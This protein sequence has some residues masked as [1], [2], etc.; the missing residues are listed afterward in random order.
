MAGQQVGDRS[1]VTA[2]QAGL[3]NAV[4]QFLIAVLQF[5]QMHRIAG[6]DHFA[7][8]LIDPRQQFRQ[9]APARGGQ[10]GGQGLVGIAQGRARRGR[11]PGQAG[12][13]L[14]QVL[15]VL[16]Q[17]VLQGRDGPRQITRIRMGGKGVEGTRLFIQKAAHVLRRRRVAGQDVAFLLGL[18]GSLSAGHGRDQGVQVLRPLK[19][20]MRGRHA[21]VHMHD[22]ACI[23]HDRQ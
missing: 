19:A 5:D 21:V 11:I 7:A 23:D 18:Q 20:Q 3:R 22:K 10:P 12:D 13:K 1:A 2:R 9:T 6:Q 8:Q 4:R 15:V 17:T 14:R 16:H